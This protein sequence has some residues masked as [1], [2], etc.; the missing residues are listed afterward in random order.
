MKTQNSTASNVMKAAWAAF[1]AQAVRTRAAFA[2]CLKAAWAAAKGVFVLTYSRNDM[3]AATRHDFCTERQEKYINNIA[4]VNFA[5]EYEFSDATLENSIS[6][7]LA[8]KIIDDVNKTYETA[9]AAAG[10][11]WNGCKINVNII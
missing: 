4:F 9:K 5:F 6:K 1:K 2:A 3:A 8:S 11:N 7:K 10:R